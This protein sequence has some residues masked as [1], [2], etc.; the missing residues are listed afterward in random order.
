MGGRCKSA[1]SPGLSEGGGAWVAE[2]STVRPG[3]CSAGGAAP[4]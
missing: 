3:S 2:A 1:Y 4:V